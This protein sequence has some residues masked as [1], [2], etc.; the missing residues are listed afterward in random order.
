MFN[1]KLKFLNY[2]SP[3]FPGMKGTLIGNSIFKYFVANHLPRSFLFIKE[4]QIHRL[5]LAS[6]NRSYYNFKWISFAMLYQFV[7]WKR[8][9][10]KCVRTSLVYKSYLFSWN[11]S[12]SVAFRFPLKMVLRNAF[13]HV[14]TRRYLDVDSTSYVRQMDVKTTLLGCLNIV[15][16][17]LRP[18][19][20]KWM[21]LINS[22]YDS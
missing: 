21:I 14:N 16:K 11:S 6:T 5:F 2:N 10:W 15:V 3:T 17:V 8:T 12:L 19:T 18:V 7:F 4:L 20:L 9:F 1:W 13:W 22:Y